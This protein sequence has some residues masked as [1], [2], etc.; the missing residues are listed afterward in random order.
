M[1]PQ[2]AFDTVQHMVQMVFFT[3]QIDKF[4]SEDSSIWSYDAAY[5]VTIKAKVNSTDA[6]AGCRRIRQLDLFLKSE[7]E[8][9]YPVTFFQ[10]GSIGRNMGP[11]LFKVFDVGGKNIHSDPYPVPVHKQFEHDLV[12]VAG[13]QKHIAFSAGFPVGIVGT[14]A[15]HAADCLIDGNSPQIAGEFIKFSV[16]NILGKPVPGRVGEFFNN[17]HFVFGVFC[18]GYNIPFQVDNVGEKGK[19]HTVQLDSGLKN[20]LAPTI[21]TP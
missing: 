11:I 18:L 21:S 16:K 6:P 19:R 17:L 8:V 15:A 10:H 1:F 2:E 3:R 14:V 5:R 9:I 13:L 7:P 20:L 4:P 12:L